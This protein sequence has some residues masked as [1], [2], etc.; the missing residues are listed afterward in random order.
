MMTSS[1]IHDLGVHPSAMTLL[2]LLATTALCLGGPGCGSRHNPIGG[3]GDGDADSD[4]DID[5]DGDTDGDG[6]VDG[7]ADGDGDMDGDADITEPLRTLGE[8]RLFGDMPLDNQVYDPSFSLLDGSGWTAMGRS[9]WDYGQVIREYRA[10]TPTGQPVLH[11]PVRRN[12]AELRVSGTVRGLP[13]TLSTSVLVGREVGD[14]D[15]ELEQVNASLVGLFRGATFEES[16]D[17]AL[18]EA[19]DPVVLEGITWRRMSAVIPEGPIG[20]AQLVIENRGQDDLFI[21]APTV[22]PLDGE[23]GARPSDAAGARLAQRRA[24]TD[25]ERVSLRAW[26]RMLGERFGRRR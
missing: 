18:D 5:G 2:L 23:R 15:E 25:G 19:E 1:R 11:V 12:P 22:V 9:M 4:G 14:E 26:R 10:R 6:D 3:D 7:D 17:L 16:V 13:V 20:W 24:L 8:R 21:T